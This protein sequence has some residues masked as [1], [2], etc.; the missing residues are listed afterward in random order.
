VIEYVDGTNLHAM[1][2]NH[3]RLSPER[4]ANYVSM[5]A[6]GLE[7]AHRAGLIHRDVKPSN[8]LLDRSGAVKLLDLGLA[9]FSRDISKNEGI[10]TRLEHNALIGTVDFMAP[11]QAID[12]SKVD[13]RSDIYS[14]GCTF[15]FLLAGRVPFPQLAFPQKIH[16][17]QTLAPEPV[18]EVCP[19]L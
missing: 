13:I 9:R 15:Y 10:T 2:D 19:R 14:L 3:G 17:H 1:V 5:T 4:A 7:H 16:A 8:I 11:E 6:A 18:S 12:S